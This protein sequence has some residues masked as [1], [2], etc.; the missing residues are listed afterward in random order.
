MQLHLGCNREHR[1][2]VW[3]GLAP[4][5]LRPDAQGASHGKARA[6]G[7]SA[8]T[9]VCH[10]SS[11]P[12]LATSFDPANQPDPTQLFNSTYLMEQ[13][14]TLVTGLEHPTA[15]SGGGAVFSYNPCFVNVAPGGVQAFATGVN[16][17]PSLAVITPEGVNIQPQGLNIQPVRA[18]RGVC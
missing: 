2:C 7:G 3:G 4:A 9:L 6:S 13:F 14:D 8:L 5:V 16:I 12:Q 11:G 1:L 18:P 10:A 17:A 15:V